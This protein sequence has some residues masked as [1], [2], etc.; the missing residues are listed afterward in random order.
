[1]AKSLN[2]LK[3]NDFNRRYLRMVELK[4]F[5]LLE[6]NGGIDPEEIEEGV[7]L[8]TCCGLGGVAIGVAAVGIYY[9]CTH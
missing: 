1:L 7:L 2:I 3:Y 4:D 5:E 8:A 9:A 6:I